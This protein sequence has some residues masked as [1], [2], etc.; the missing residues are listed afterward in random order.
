MRAL[1]ALALALGGCAY[2]K[3]SAN[4]STGLCKAE[5][6]I[7]Q[8][9]PKAVGIMAEIASLII[10]QDYTQAFLIIGQE[11][12]EEAE[13]IEDTVDAQ[14]S[15]AHGAMSAEAKMYRSA[16]VVYKLSH[17]GTP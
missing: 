9:G 7:T 8:C 4:A 6:S 11:A 2:C 15:T 17:K 13:C 5:R 16:R 3:V 10:A 1:L 14:I 12:P